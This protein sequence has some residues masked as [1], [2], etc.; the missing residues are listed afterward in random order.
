MA[1]RD[2]MV[3]GFLML[4]MVCCCLGTEAPYPVGEQE[5]SNAILRT[6]NNTQERLSTLPLLEVQDDT[7]EWH[8][9]VLG[10]G[11]A[12]EKFG[13]F[14]KKVV[15]P[16]IPLE[17]KNGKVIKWSE[18]GV[19]SLVRRRRAASKEAEEEGGGGEVISNEE[20]AEE[21]PT[22]ESLAWVDPSTLVNQ[23]YSVENV[24]SLANLMGLRVIKYR[25]QPIPSRLGTPSS[26]YSPSRYRTRPAQYP[27][28][29]RP[30]ASDPSYKRTDSKSLGYDSNLF[31]D[32]FHNSFHSYY[33]E[34]NDSLPYSNSHGPP[35]GI[36]SWRRSQS[37]SGESRYPNNS[38]TNGRPNQPY[39][40]SGGGGGGGGS[41]LD[42]LDPLNL[43][44]GSQGPPPSR[45]PNPVPPPGYDPRRPRPQQRPSPSNSRSETRDSQG[46]K[47]E[48]IV[49]DKGNHGYAFR[50]NYPLRDDLYVG[51]DGNIYI[52][53]NS[54]EDPTVPYGDDPFE[55]N[56]R[57]QHTSGHQ[58]PYRPQSRPDRVRPDRV[59]P[60]RVRPDRVRPDRV[61][62]KFP[63]NQY[64][65]ENTYDENEYRELLKN[66][67]LDDYSAREPPASIQ[68]ILPEDNPNYKSNSQ[69][70]PRGQHNGRYQNYGRRP[71]KPNRNPGT[72]YFDWFTPVRGRIN[73]PS[74]FTDP[75]Q[76]R[77]PGFRYPPRHRR[78]PV[79]PRP[80]TPVIPPNV[81]HP[82]PTQRPE[83]TQRRPS[84]PNSP[85]PRSSFPKSSPARPSFS[86]PSPPRQR[87]SFPISSPPRS[88]PNFDRPLSDL[89]SH[90]NT[91]L[92]ESSGD[93]NSRVTPGGT[94]GFYPGNGFFD[95]DFP[96]LFH[97]L[98]SNRHRVYEPLPRPLAL[99]TTVEEE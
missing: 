67:N 30:M 3:T 59:R 84:F 87:P 93:G 27:K 80:G 39:F 5:E 36:S 35:Q 81:R 29:N 16:K 4:T 61:R 78:M 60:D 1:Q 79:P 22:P 46:A 70:T 23:G 71:S 65:D 94:K 38:P 85:P 98:P 48:V 18:G 44:K 19:H 50:E 62:P 95:A 14:D 82:R 32:M 56:S 96:T 88:R 11:N 55:E 91:R 15:D 24:P 99:N 75:R 47:Y 97:M 7:G 20:E 77:L 8:E 73:Y 72:R 28:F 2:N 41:L 25:N 83:L 42:M 12:T 74:F 21:L 51:V 57:P 58:R 54:V 76:V 49:E 6:A 31:G 64:K 37:S 52:K 63:R 53:D 40:P 43:F 17:K 68:D 45:H 10:S 26:S 33:K 13:V 86:N 90:Q 92:R 89:A 66:H 9:R 34:K 69:Q